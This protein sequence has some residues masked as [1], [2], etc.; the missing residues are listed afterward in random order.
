[1]A[2]DIIIEAD[3]CLGCGSCELACAIFHSTSQ[4]LFTA[5]REDP[6]PLSR[7]RVDIIGGEAFPTLCRHCEYAP[8]I[9]ACMASAM[10][11]EE[12]GHLVLVDKERCVG[13]WMCVMV[14]PFTAI[15]V[16]SNQKKAVK[17]DKCPGEEVPWC[18]SWCPTNAIHYGE[19]EALGQAAL[20]ERAERFSLPLLGSTQHRKG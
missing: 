7:I 6:L 4:N 9:D 15:V 20:R 5:I 11:R 10:H 12:K 3:K 19:I 1:M 16:D 8:C 17:C 14:C 2:R 13:C 18:V